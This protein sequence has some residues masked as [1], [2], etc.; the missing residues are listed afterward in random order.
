MIVVKYLEAK[1][2]V[3]RCQSLKI[4]HLVNLRSIIRLLWVSS[5]FIQILYSLSFCCI[6]RCIQLMY[7]NILLLGTTTWKLHQLLTKKILYFN[8]FPLLIYHFESY[9]I[10]MMGDGLIKSLLCLFNIIFYALIWKLRI[11]LSNKL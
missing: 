8:M 2:R 5:S 3:G 11:Q 4:I 6:L 1:A 7:N 10:L 9:Y